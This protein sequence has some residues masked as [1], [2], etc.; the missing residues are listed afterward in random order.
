MLI[1]C[2]FLVT[3]SFADG[4]SI[5]KKWSLKIDIDSHIFQ[6]FF[7]NNKVYIPTISSQ[8][9][10]I[11]YLTGEKL[12]E[13]DSCC[14]IKKVILGKVF[15]LRYSPA[16]FIICVDENSGNIL[17]KQS[18][19]DFNALFL[20]DS[21]YAVVQD[22]DDKYMICKY[23]LNGVLLSKYKNKNV[24]SYKIEKLDGDFLYVEQLTTDYYYENVNLD[25]NTL[26]FKDLANR[27]P[28][29]RN[30][31]G[32]VFLDN[33]CIVITRQSKTDYYLSLYDKKVESKLWSLKIGKER[34]LSFH[35]I[36]NNYLYI[37]TI[38]DE[39]HRKLYCL[40][41]KSGKIVWMFGRK[42]LFDSFISNNCL[43]I[44]DSNRHNSVLFLYKLDLRT[45]STIKATAF[46]NNDV[47]YN[48][49][50]ING[51]LY[52]FNKQKD[53]ICLE[54][55]DIETHNILNAVELSFKSQLIKAFTN[56]LLIRDF[57]RREYI[58]INLDTN[59][60]I[61]FETYYNYLFSIEN[62]F[63]FYN[64]KDKLL[65]CHVTTGDL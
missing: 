5:Y 19:F 43:N 62:Q 28:E 8:I 53:K 26:E 20:D 23:D 11:N 60:L 55:I 16:P 13:V 33:Y 6:P 46:S 17:W 52:I 36:I 9:Y 54:I 27:F 49:N 14:A 58:L 22:L 50:I 64:Y 38:N 15:I 42:S 10:C 45:G 7:A 25:K 18:I 63:F 48:N 4:V 24:V 12:W 35:K 61:P 29:V 44:I 39:L 57:F 21:I 30:L 40:E 3:S 1:I 2:S 32:S 41:I 37:D 65:E 47:Q 56:H 51:K 34:L 31:L 59:Q